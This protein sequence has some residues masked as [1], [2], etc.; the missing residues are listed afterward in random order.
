MSPLPP[1]TTIFMLHLPVGGPRAGAVHRSPPLAGVKASRGSVSR[2]RRGRCHVDV[3][4][5]HTVGPL[6]VRVQPCR[7]LSGR[8]RLLPALRACERAAGNPRAPSE[9]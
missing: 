8:A 4:A 5:A 3:T 1:I 9:S 2:R 6:L 7:E